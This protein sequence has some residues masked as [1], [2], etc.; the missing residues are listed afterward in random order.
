M[1]WLCSDSSRGRTGQFQPID[2][3][4]AAEVHGRSGSFIG[5][6]GV[7]IQ[8]ERESGDCIRSLLD[9]PQILAGVIGHRSN[10]GFY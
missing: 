7:L 3:V 6:I 8:I 2:A 1:R 10:P 5:T 4:A 9:I